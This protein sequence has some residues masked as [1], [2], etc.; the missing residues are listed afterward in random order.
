MN[1]KNNAYL[2]FLTSNSYM[3]GVL[4]LK[5]TL[6][7][8]KTKYP[9]YCAITD[10]ISAE[11]I[12]TLKKCNVQLI[13]I[14]KIPTPQHIYEHNKSLNPNQAEIWKDVLTK[15]QAWNMT[16]F[17]KIIM[18]DCDLMILKNIDHCFE[19]DDGTA[20]LDGEYF[21]L[22]P[23]W[24]HFN[25]GFMV[26]KPDAAKFISMLAFAKMIDPKK[27]YDAYGRHYL[28]ADQ[29]ILN[30]YYK[31]W[32]NDR[33][34]HLNKYY[35]IFA[36]HAAENVVDDIFSNA[37]FVHFVGAKPWQRKSDGTSPLLD[38]EMKR[39]R[40]YKLYAVAGAYLEA[41]SVRFAENTLDE[42]D[43]DKVYTSGELFARG[44]ALLA[45]VYKDLDGATDFAET[46]I[47]MAQ[48]SNSA[49]LNNYINLRKSI[50]DAK[51]INNYQKLIY[52]I[53]EEIYKE[54][55]VDG[56]VSFNILSDL[57]FIE[58]NESVSDKQTILD[59]WQYI[60]QA[61]VKHAS[62]IRKH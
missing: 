16:Q 22:W 55:H 2:T 51:N 47:L 38:T 1:Q 50:E 36:P 60:K 20:A 32:K 12:E 44:A 53:M 43:W 59:Y 24:S 56:S 10:D 26:I 37:Y 17:D 21:N 54:T 19:L 7:A 46:S 5:C 28:I 18:L 45:N 57:A 30:L 29:E 40:A 62:D 27:H 11:T 58:R 23:D 34:L 4:L 31:D 8:V 42:L 3:G 9:L 48:T 14:E 49:D 15:L 52:P 35:N 6:D 33:H 25:S 39:I 41:W 13:N 61:L